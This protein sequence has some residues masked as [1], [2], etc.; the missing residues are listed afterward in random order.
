[1]SRKMQWLASRNLRHPRTKRTKDEQRP[2]YRLNRKGQ[3]R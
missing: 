3:K 1:M 2:N